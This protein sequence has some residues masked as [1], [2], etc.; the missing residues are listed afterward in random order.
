MKKCVFLAAVMAAVAAMAGYRETKGVS[1]WSEKSLEKASEYQKTT[2]TLDIKVP[3]GAT[4]FATYVF[5]HGGGLYRGTPCYPYYPADDETIARVSVSYRLMPN[6][7]FAQCIEDAAA[8]TAWVLD[9][10]AEYG[11]DPTKVVIGGHSA[12]GYL[13]CMVGMDPRW[14]GAFGHKPTDLM[15]LIPIS[16]QVTEHFAVRKYAGDV[17]PQYLPKINERAPLHYVAEKF[18]PICLICG[19]R[20][21]EWKCRVEE[22]E[23]MF[24]SIQNCA[25]GR[26]LDEFHECSGKNHGTVSGPAREIGQAFVRKLL[27]ARCQN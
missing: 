20:K 17:D 5:F 8:A 1:Y 13:T 22:N 27:A 10:I 23:F 19:D 2:C 16:G 6:C 26:R 18:P 14:L 7:G 25:K 24:A 4:N 3:E 21:L 9:H 15:G 11:G 12:G